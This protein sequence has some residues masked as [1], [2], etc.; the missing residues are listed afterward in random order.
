MNS[1]VRCVRCGLPRPTTTPETSGRIWAAKCCSCGGESPNAIDGP[2]LASRVIERFCHTV[3]ACDLAVEVKCKGC[4][5]PTRPGEAAGFDVPGVI[6]CGTCASRYDEA[7]GA[8]G[9]S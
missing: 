1:T 6:Y 7:R 3:G 8:G 4:G 2:E 9:R 5:V